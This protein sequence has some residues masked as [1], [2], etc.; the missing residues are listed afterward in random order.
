MEKNLCIACMLWISVNRSC[1]AVTMCEPILL[2]S[3][4]ICYFKMSFWRKDYFELKALARQV[5]EGH[6][7][8]SFSSWKKEIKGPYQNALLM[9]RGSIHSPETGAETEYSVQT[10]LRKQVLFSFVSPCILATFSTTA[11]PWSPN[12]SALRFCRFF[13]SLFSCGNFHVC[14]KIKF[15]CFSHV[16]LP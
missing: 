15:V 5:L 4:G 6:S 1:S 16:N 3:G 14:V 10:N 13:G 2:K 11:S 7:D 9:L 8:F 12:I